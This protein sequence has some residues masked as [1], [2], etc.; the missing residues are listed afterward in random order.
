MNYPCENCIKA[1]VCKYKEEI[2]DQINKLTMNDQTD[3]ITIT[4]T[5]KYAKYNSIARFD[6]TPIPCYSNTVNSNTTTYD[7]E[8][9][10]II[11]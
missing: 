6:I 5:C 1:D 8:N 7:N 10:W 3:I 2:K 4:Y 9:S 11:K